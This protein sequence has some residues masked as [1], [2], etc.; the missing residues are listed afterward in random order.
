MVLDH[1]DPGVSLSDLEDAVEYLL[2]C[3]PDLQISIYSGHLIKDQL[4]DRLSDI[5]ADNTSLWIAQYTSAAAPSWPKGTWAVW[6][7]WQYTDQAEVSGISARVDGNRWN[8][9]IENLITWFGP[10]GEPVPEP[11]PEPEAGE[12]LVSVIASPGVKVTVMV[13]GETKQP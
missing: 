8:G 10:A 13:N 4:G 1:E 9:S 11:A 2:D 6:S 12:V 5:L 7:L 3:R